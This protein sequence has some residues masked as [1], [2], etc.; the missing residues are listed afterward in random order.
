MTRRPPPATPR[1]RTRGLAPPARAARVSTAA[2]GNSGPRHGLARVLSKLGV[3]SRT[4]AARRIADGRVSV[5]GRVIRDPEFPIRTHQPAAIAI[6]GQPLAGPARIY[7]M[8]N[9]PRGVV[10]TVRDEQGRDT[11]YRCFD[12]AGLPWIAPVG[13][14]DKAS[15]GLL[16]FSNDPQWAAA[17]TDP[18]SGPDKTYHV[19]IDCHP[20]AGQLEQLQVGVIDPDPDGDGGVLRAK[21]VRLLREGERNAW[22]EIV[23]D[24]GRNR[25]IR[26]LLAAVDIGV[27]RLVRVAIGPLAI[28]ELDKGAWRMLSAAE[29]LA[30]TPA[31]ASAPNAR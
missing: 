23:L 26:R 15:E 22:L 25:Q 20:D 10:T 2:P 14:L 28:G 12:G 29:V 8:L 6:D 13:R 18:A 19:Q 17:V 21:Q 1:P 7:V 11:V 9:K 16:L 31:R 27:L 24:E 3:C 5:D 4:E 30:L